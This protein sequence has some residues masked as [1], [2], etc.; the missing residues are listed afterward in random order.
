[1]SR[2]WLRMM[3]PALAGVG[4]WAAVKHLFGRAPAQPW[5]V[6]SL[7][8]GHA[9]AR[10][11]LAVDREAVDE[12]KL[13]K[14]AALRAWDD[15][16]ARLAAYVHPAPPAVAPSPPPAAPPRPQWCVKCDKPLSECRCRA[17]EPT[18]MPPTPSKATAGAAGGRAAAAARWAVARAAGAK[19]RRHRVDVDAA[20]GDDLSAAAAAAA[21][22]ALSAAVA[23]RVDRTRVRRRRSAVTKR[24]K[25]S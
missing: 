2:D 13:W 5:L 10:P 24:G 7:H 8:R 4:L 11:R 3:V 19:A 6:L 9:F 21:V 15:L 22:G 14:A 1:M 16:H 17:P 12:I 18:V 23:G 20:G 25:R